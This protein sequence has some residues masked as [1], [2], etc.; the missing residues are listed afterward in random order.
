M[1]SKRQ[2]Q[3]SPL[4]TSLYGKDYAQKVYERLEELDPELNQVIQGVAYDQFWSRDGLSIRDKS[5]ITVASLIATGK[6]EQTRIHMTGFLNSGGSIDELRNAL[7]HLAVYCGFPAIM[8][9]FAALKEIVPQP[10]TGKLK[11]K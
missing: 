10:K 8:N 11:K 2:K 3:Q 6:A 1:K 9:G 4:M 7:I 5:L